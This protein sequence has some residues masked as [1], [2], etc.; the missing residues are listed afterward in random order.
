VVALIMFV[1][2][3]ALLF[4]VYAGYPLLITV[5]ARQ[6][7]RE[8]ERQQATTPCVTVVFCAHNEAEVL[9]EKIQQSAKKLIVIQIPA[10]QFCK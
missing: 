8:Q 5:C 2:S 1:A 9:P 7:G 10:L 3:A 4:Y 6:W